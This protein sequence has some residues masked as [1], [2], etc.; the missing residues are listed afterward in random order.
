MTTYVNGTQVGGGGGGGAGTVVTS[1]PVSGDG[2]SGTP[3][4]IADGAIS[5]AKMAAAATTVGV[6]GSDLTFQG[7]LVIGANSKETL[8]GT[9]NA[10][11]TVTYHFIDTSGG[12]ANITL[13]NSATTD[14]LHCFIDKARTFATNKMTL[15][16]GASATINGSSSS[17]DFTSTGTWVWLHK[18][19]ALSWVICNEFA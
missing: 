6:S 2:S 9:A 14:S 1:S 12:V 5:Q 16:P 17:I 11:A 8:S 18:T 19:G 15:T 10:S 4:T 7:S 13:P 3:V